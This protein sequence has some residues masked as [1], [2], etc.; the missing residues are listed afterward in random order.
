MKSILWIIIII[1]CFGV[2]IFLFQTISI[3]LI[4]PKKPPALILHGF[5]GTE[6]SMAGMLE[7]FEL[8][9]E[10]THVQTCTVDK[11]G[12]LTWRNIKTAKSN[13]V[14]LIHIVFQDN[15]ASLQQQ[16]KW[17]A[18][19]AMITRDEYETEGITMIA[20]SMGGLA[21]LTYIAD[22]SWQPSYP[23]VERLVTLGTPV[24]GL[25]MK[26][27]LAQYPKAKAAE[28]SPAAIALSEGSAALLHLHR[29]LADLDKYDVHI[30]SI[31]GHSQK[32]G[33]AKGD[34]SVTE[35]SALYLR[36]FSKKVKTASFPLT[37]F[38]LHESTEVD[39]AVYAF[40]KEKEAE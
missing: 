18:K 38:H 3:R 37:H 19:I 15:T 32:M 29:Q 8:N 10:G 11:N 23:K 39:E 25:N 27:L 6:R 1:S 7:R 14:P 21:A 5:R 28:D 35:E 24:S 2:V 33:E 36:Q 31:A 30:L 34:G 40:L 17:L 9:G 13:S 4:P 20:H 22:Y 12:K 26:H 16:V